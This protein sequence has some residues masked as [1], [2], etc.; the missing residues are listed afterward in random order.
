MIAGRSAEIISNNVTTKNWRNL[1]NKELDNMN[2]L[3]GNEMEN[4]CQTCSKHV[5]EEDIHL[6]RIVS[7]E[8]TKWQT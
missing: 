1:H 7:W 8:N 3:Q 2:S 4:M 5:K 6:G